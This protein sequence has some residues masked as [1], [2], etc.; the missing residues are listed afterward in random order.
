MEESSGF[1]CKFLTS[2][3][4]NGAALNSA[5]ANPFE[6]MM[7][8]S[9]G[10]LGGRSA[11]FVAVLDTDSG[12]HRTGS[13]SVPMEWSY[14]SV[15][16]TTMKF[17]KWT[18][19]TSHSRC[20]NSCPSASRA[21]KQSWC[22]FQWASCFRS[23]ASLE[24]QPRKSMCMAPGREKNAHQHSQENAEHYIQNGRFAFGSFAD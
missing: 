8:R 5:G 12:S 11:D 22:A 15:I 24:R 17:L 23:R 13:A 2:A 1:A 14:R 7:P 19:R 20:W 4:A 6:S 3:V 18:H 21:Q 9:T 10:A 16:W